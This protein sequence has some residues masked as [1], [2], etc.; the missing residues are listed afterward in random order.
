YI[1]DMEIAKVLYG[2][3]D[4]DGKVDTDDAIIIMKKVLG[5]TES[6][7]I[8]SMKGYEGEDENG[9]KSYLKYVDMDGDKIISANDS[10]IIM[11]MDNVY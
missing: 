2:D 3:A 1:G 6:L 7:P 11:G 5:E 8:E 4:G 9:E 10:A